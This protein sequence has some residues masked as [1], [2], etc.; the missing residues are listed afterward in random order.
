M[1]AP[2]DVR[3]RASRALSMPVAF[4]A[5]EDLELEDGPLAS[6]S[7][8]RSRV[9]RDFFWADLA[10]AFL[11]VE[12]WA[13]SSSARRE[14]FSAFLAAAAARLASASS[15]CV[16]DR[17]SVLEGSGGGGGSCRQIRQD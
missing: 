13:D 1:L 16:F 15:L 4:R 3:D 12:R 2:P 7:W 6:S 14:A 11:G 8:P 9:P 5:A 17:S 10:L